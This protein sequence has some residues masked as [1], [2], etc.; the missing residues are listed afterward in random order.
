MIQVCPITTKSVNEKATRINALF[1][2]VLTTA[3]L[4]FNAQWILAVLLFDFLSRGFGFQQYSIFKI[5]SEYITELL[6]IQPTYTNAGPKQFAA[7]IGAL[8]SLASLV[9]YFADLQVV[10]YGTAGILLFFSFLEAA[11]SF[12]LA[13]KIYPWL[14][15]R[16]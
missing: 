12:C 16:L 1:T 2:V 13:C 9:T 7:R 8:I 14:A 5:V 3:Y 15:P 10:S 4:L 11:F 6:N